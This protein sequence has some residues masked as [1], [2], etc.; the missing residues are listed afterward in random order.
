LT[1]VAAE[2]GGYSVDFQFG[3]LN[4]GAAAQAIEIPL[5]P[6]SLQVAQSANLEIHRDY[7]FYV[8]HFRVFQDDLKDAFRYGKLMHFTPA[9]AAVVFC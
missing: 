1:R 3:P 7:A 4:E 8:V 9:Q 6:L 5:D 2:C